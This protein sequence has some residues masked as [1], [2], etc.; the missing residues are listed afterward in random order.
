MADKPLIA[1]TMGDPAGVGPEVCLKW[2]NRSAAKP[3]ANFV[4]VGDAAVMQIVARAIGEPMNLNTTEAGDPDHFEYDQTIGLL[5]LENIDAHDVSPGKV[6]R[7]A[8][9][10]SFEYVEFA[11]RAALAGRVDAVVTCPIA[12]SAWA[13][14]GITFPGHTEA[15]AEMTGTKSFGM[16]LYSDEITVTLATCHCP[17]REVPSLLT[18]ERIV[19]VI[20]LTHETLG[21]LTG[22]KPQVGVCGLNPHAGEDGL[23]GDED[24]RIVAP[25]IEE[26]RALGIQAEGP[27]SPDTAFTPHRLRRYDGF[28]CMYHDQGL[29]PFKMAAFGK[30]TNVTMGL[31]IVRTSV[32]HGTAFDIAW[33]G[34]ADIGGLDAAVTLAAKMVRMKG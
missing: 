18:R 27:I 8:G 2:L 26:A 22:R 4:V 12:K 21:R 16:M 11:V 14:E 9:R 32:D 10:A 29:I 20:R 17:I 31:P 3:D 30:G 25:A 34:K 15:L 5:D 1:I 33:Q 6:S 28:V 7:E 19:E 24:Q 13:A 23:L